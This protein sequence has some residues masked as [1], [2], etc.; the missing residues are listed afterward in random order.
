MSEKL[1]TRRRRRDNAADAA[2]VKLR[3]STLDGHGGSMAEKF[4]AS[5]AEKEAKKQSMAQLEGAFK[6][7]GEKKAMEMAK[8]KDE[9][10]KMMESDEDDSLEKR[11]A[12]RKAKADK[13]ARAPK[14]MKNAAAFL[15]QAQEAEKK[16]LEAE[17]KRREKQDREERRKAKKDLE[18]KGEDV[19]EHKMLAG[20][21][22]PSR[23]PNKIKTN[24]ADIAAKEEED[25]LRKIADQRMS[26]INNENK[27]M[28]K[29]KSIWEQGIGADE[30]Q[31]NGT[32]NTSGSGKS[33]PKKLNMNF[34]EM[35]EYRQQQEQQR[36]IEERMKRLREENEHMQREYAERERNGSFDADDDNTHHKSTLNSERVSNPGKITSVNFLKEL[37]EIEKLEQDLA[38]ITDEKHALEKIIENCNAEAKTLTDVHPLDFPDDETY[39]KYME[40]IQDQLADLNNK[41][42]QTQEIL[43]QTSCAERQLMRLIKQELANSGNSKIDRKGA[44]NETF[45]KFDEM[46]RKRRKEEEDKLYEEKMKKLELERT[47]LRHQQRMFEMD[48][49]QEQ[50]SEAMD[51][52][53]MKGL[54]TIKNAPKKLDDKFLMFD[55]VNQGRI[56][57]EKQELNRQKME[58]LREE[59]LLFKEQQADTTAL[60]ESSDDEEEMDSRIKRTPISKV[61]KVNVNFDKAAAEEFE[62]Q[63]QELQSEKMKL[64]EEEIRF[65]KMQQKYDPDG[66]NS[67]DGDRDVKS[68]VNR[69]PIKTDDVLLRAPKKLNRKL[70]ENTDLE[71]KRQIEAERI[72]KERDEKLRQ[73]REMF[74][75]Q[76]MEQDGLNSSDDENKITTQI[77]SSST[78]KQNKPGP[79][80]K[81]GGD[82]FLKKLQEEQARKD[83][84]ALLAAKMDRMAMEHQEMMLSEQKNMIDGQLYY[85]DDDYTENSDNENDVTSESGDESDQAAGAPIFVKHLEKTIEVM[86]GH[87]V[88]FDTQVNMYPRGK[89]TWYYNRRPIRSSEDYQYLSQGNEYSLYMPETFIDDSGEYICKIENSKGQTTSICNLVILE[90]PNLDY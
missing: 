5:L 31:L 73:E 63:R 29:Q 54:A 25:R 34:A 43:L 46:E 1:T 88:R 52:S 55:A 69:H 8:F 81:I 85:S 76:Q 3:T 24:F 7:L 28:S 35:E 9:M 53:L 41:K 58:K 26:R 64:L 40:N 27:E 75:Q 13:A 60:G 23:K 57:Q 90:D 36:I 14:K 42:N 45:S 39:D 20:N 32:T 6:K 72:K 67:S 82:F 66:D 2:N 70:F 65:M 78:S 33:Q 10:A 62:R 51:D 44:K 30:E 19:S 83:Q 87:P 84:E 18:E 68:S 74:A 49:R 15:E 56:F 48:Q 37:S 17:R 21:S 50:V 16:K 47:Q 59:M 77:S 89:V 11:R 79:K 38:K 4:A 61:G 22:R 80:K 12:A 86:E 71:L